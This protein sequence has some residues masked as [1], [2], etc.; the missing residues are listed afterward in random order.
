MILLLEDNIRG[1]IGSIMGDRYVKSDDNKKLLYMDA[2]NLYGHSMSESLPHDEIEYDI[3]VKL[4]DILN[5]PDDSDIGYFIEIDSN[6]PD[7]IKE[8]TK[9]FPFCPENKILVKDKFNE[10]MKQIKPKNFKKSQ[11]II[12][13]WNDKKSYLVHYRMLKFYIRHGMIADKVHE[14][15]SFEQSK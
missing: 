15:N 7:K 3:N 1:S 5:T 10:Y 12:C 4:E 14:I 9:K 8:K 13:D 11:K 2:A 6:Y